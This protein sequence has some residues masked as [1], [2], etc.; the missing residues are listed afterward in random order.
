M[1]KRNAADGRAE[2]LDVDAGADIGSQWSGDPLARCLAAA[3]R[4]T[5]HAFTAESQR[6]D[7]LAE[8][9]AVYRQLVGDAEVNSERVAAT[10]LVRSHGSFLAATSLALSG[11]VAEAYVLMRSAMEAALHGLYIAGSPERQKQ[12]LNRNDDP[13]SGQSAVD[14]LSEGAASAHL[15]ELDAEAARVY[16]KLHSR[17]LQRAVHPNTYANLARVKPPGD[18][19]DFN[20]EYFVC[21][22]EVQRSCLRSAAQAGICS[23]SIFFFAFADRYRA[24]QLGD[25]INQLRKAH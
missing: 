2:A 12:W 20:R 1:P 13:S 5:V 9:D 23:L 18:D 21:D 7:A 22:D 10:F 4:N 24:L 6:Y 19:G 11:Q 25:R 17:T 8:V 15:Q 3:W 14:M 16:E